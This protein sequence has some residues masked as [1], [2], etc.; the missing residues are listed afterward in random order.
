MMSSRQSSPEASR[1]NSHHSLH[2]SSRASM[3]ARVM[4]ADALVSGA[5]GLL[6]VLAA[7]PLA[8]LL[9]LPAVGLRVTGLVLLVY[10]AALVWLVRR[11]ALPAG[12]AWTVIGINVIWA[13]DCALLLASDWIAPNGL[14]MAFIGIQIATVLMFAELT[15][16]GLRR[17]RQVSV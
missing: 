16:I 8:G 5:V 7:V 1:H 9:D 4:L 15:F 17:R 10:G 14:G 11:T 3:L 13:L 12:A 2:S 6:Q